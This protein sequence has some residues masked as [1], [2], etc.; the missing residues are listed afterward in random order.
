MQVLRIYANLPGSNWAGNLWRVEHAHNT[1]KVTWHDKSPFEMVHGHLPIKIS[2][3]L[4]GSQLPAVKQYLD[5]IVMQQKIANDA[6]LLAQF[7]TAETAAKRR[8]P[9]ISFKEGNS[10]LYKRRNITK[11]KSRKLHRVRIRPC[12][13]LAVN[14]DTGNCL[15]EIPDALK[16]YPWFAINKPKAL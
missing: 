12:Q 5:H 3:E 13:T 4:S 16:I 8:N 6:L 15:L 9:K 11:K 10:I 14:E 2:R 1:A 7:R